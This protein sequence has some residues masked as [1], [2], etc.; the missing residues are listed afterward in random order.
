MSMIDGLVAIRPYHARWTM[1]VLAAVALGA[2]VAV[3]AQLLAA[4]VALHTAIPVWDQLDLPTPGEIQRD[5]F[6]RHNE[7]LIVLPRLGFLLDLALTRGGNGVNIATIQLIQAFHAVLLAWV[8]AAGRNVASDDPAIAAK[9]RWPDPL[10]LG[11]SLCIVFSAQQFENLSW[12]FQTQF[13]GV[14]ALATSCFAVLLFGGVGAGATAGACLLGAAAVLTMANGVFILPIATVLAFLAGRPWK[15]VA[16][17]SVAALAVGIGFVAT[18]VPVPG[19]SSPGDALRQPWRVA[20]YLATYI[21]AGPLHVLGIPSPGGMPILASA[22]IGSAGLALAAFLG[23]RALRIRQRVAPAEWVLL[24]LAG[25]IV[26]SAAATAAGRFTLGYGQATSS[27]YSTPALLFWCA[28][29]LSAWILAGR[30]SPRRL[31]ATGAAIAIVAALAA[32]QQARLLRGLEEFVVQR[33]GAET[34]LVAGVDDEAAFRIIYPAPEIV[35]RSAERL[36]AAR[37]S[38]FA[39]AYVDWIGRP[40]NG[41]VRLLASNRCRGF[42][43][44]ATIQGVGA[45]HFT[46]ARGWAWDEAERRRIT[47]VLLVDE[48][49][50]IVGF[51]RGPLRRSDVPRGTEGAV[52]DPLVGWAGHAAA[53]PGTTLRA[54]ALAEHDAACPLEGVIRVVGERPRVIGREDI[55]GVRP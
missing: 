23:I 1:A 29:L 9:R 13:V 27:R 16:A 52:S 30:H 47:R 25:F 3:V 14:F 51:G 20:I 10:A 2:A 45:A 5:L 6:K 41:T 15:Q 33:Y 8:A 54:F 17:L 22:V 43:D 38:V 36:R 35:R 12:G 34:A 48:A 46:T 32:T 31:L 26:L 4:L 49:G 53:A 39:P 11:L 21:G 44:N 19:H 37:L 28:L 24:G 50:Q 40:L 42:L 55:A 18:H 7:H